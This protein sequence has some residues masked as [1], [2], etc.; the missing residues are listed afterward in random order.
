V[1]R[2]IIVMLDFHIV[3]TQELTLLATV[4]SRPFFASFMTEF[5]LKNKLFRFKIV[6]LLGKEGV[7]I[8]LYVSANNLESLCAVPI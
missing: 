7:I 1:S 2:V 4:F 5:I 3:Q 6:L 8:E